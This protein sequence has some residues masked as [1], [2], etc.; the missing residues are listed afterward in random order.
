MSSYQYR[1]P[2]ITDKTAVT[3]LSLRWKTHTLKIRFF[4]WDGAQ[5]S[6]QGSETDITHITRTRGRGTGAQHYSVTVRAAAITI[7]TSSVTSNVKY[8]TL[9]TS[10]VK[11][12]YNQL[13][14]NQKPQSTLSMGLICIIHI[15]IFDVVAHLLL[16]LDGPCWYITLLCVFSTRL[17]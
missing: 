17:Y 5:I 12:A 6:K 11:C 1:D 7:V 10:N 8:T 3:V 14:A 13:S 2:R 4:Y 9:V 15:C 16:W